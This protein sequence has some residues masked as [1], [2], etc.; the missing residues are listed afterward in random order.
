M[1]EIE[2]TKNGLERR[3]VIKGAAW[4]VPVI[5][6]AVA[7]PLA[8]ASVVPTGSIVVESSC[9]LAILP[10][11]VG[12]PVGLTPVGFTVKNTSSLA[13]TVTLSMSAEAWGAAD[14]TASNNVQS[15]TSGALWNSQSA[16]G[17]ASATPAGFNQGWGSITTVSLGPLAGYR[18]SRTRTVTLTL[19]AGS[20]YSFGQFL[21][22]NLL[23]DPTVNAT[24]TAINGKT[25]AGDGAYLNTGLICVAG[26]L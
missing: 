17:G 4:S 12:L 6:V 5:A 22:L 26:D 8:A 14:F 16:T 23:G 10:F 1:S 9:S 18:A 25:V 24:V 20:S 2:T 21:A 19:P 13:A 7:T 3:S 15:A 11:P